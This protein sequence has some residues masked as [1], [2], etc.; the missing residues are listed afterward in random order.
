MI[1]KS[2]YAAIVL[3]STAVL[4]AVVLVIV[5]IAG[6]WQVMAPLPP[7]PMAILT[8]VATQSFARLILS[9]WIYPKKFV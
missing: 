7:F 8:Q 3:G 1:K 9:I 5:D 6:L 4:L 2:V